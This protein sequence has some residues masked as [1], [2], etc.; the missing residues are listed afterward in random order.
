MR[1]FFSKVRDPLKV[2]HTLYCIAADTNYL[3]IYSHTGV[4]PEILKR[5]G[6]LSATIFKRRRKFQLSDGLKR[7]KQRQKL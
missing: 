2:R 7:P 3:N 5:G 4:D 1:G 6:A